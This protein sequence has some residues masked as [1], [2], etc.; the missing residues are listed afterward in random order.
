M[1]SKY[2]KEAEGIKSFIKDLTHFGLSFVQKQAA[3]CLNLNRMKK[4][5][6]L[7][8]EQISIM[9]GLKEGEVVN[10]LSGNYDYTISHLTAFDTHYFE[11]EQAR[12]RVL[13]SE[14]R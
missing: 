5:F 14:K 4:D 12:D 6:N 2:D 11:L 3:F 10:F 9:F 13:I 8:D 1:E 7:T